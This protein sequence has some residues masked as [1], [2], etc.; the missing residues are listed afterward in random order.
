[1]GN[2][3]FREID[4]V[5]RRAELHLFVGDDS[6]RGKGYGSNALR[7]AV[8]YAVSTLGI[9]RVWLQVLSENHGA[10]EDS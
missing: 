2:L 8:G 4:W 3:Y 6:E 7:L 5:H 9:H 1:M 10:I